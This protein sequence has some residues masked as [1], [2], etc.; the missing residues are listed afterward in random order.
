MTKTQKS[1]YVYIS[2]LVVLKEANRR[3]NIVILIILLNNIELNWCKCYI[4]IYIYKYSLWMFLYITDK[5][6]KMNCAILNICAY[7]SNNLLYTHNMVKIIIY[8]NSELNIFNQNL[9]IPSHRWLIISYIRK[10]PCIHFLNY[11]EILS[12]FLCFIFVRSNIFP[13]YR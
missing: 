12:S 2:S 3:D 9:Y 7:F 13:T 6:I 5:H 8:R 4:Y 1:I 10:E 11:D